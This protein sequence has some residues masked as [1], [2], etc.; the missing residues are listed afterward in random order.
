MMKMG[1]ISGP[2]NPYT[3][4]HEWDTINL[5]LANGYDIQMLPESRISG[6]HTPDIRMMNLCWEMKSP[7]SDSS[8]I[9]RNTLRDAVKQSS[10]IIIDLR[11]TKR[12]DLRCLYEIKKWYTGRNTT[13]N[14]WVI[15]KQG[16]I[17]K[18]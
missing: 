14:I 12:H 2:I 11:R 9:I 17:I 5:L 16:K 6:V 7:K 4:P 15:S 3:R 10:N 13:K 1:K 18:F 8:D